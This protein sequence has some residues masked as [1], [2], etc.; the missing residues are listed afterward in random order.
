[1]YLGTRLKDE[2]SLLVE[3]YI[4]YETSTNFLFQNVFFSCSFLAGFPVASP[5]LIYGRAALLGLSGGE[6]SC[7]QTY[8]KCPKNEASFNKFTRF[9]IIF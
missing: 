8:E 4:W 1:M 3:T 2:I 7:I 5:A 9:R 6:R